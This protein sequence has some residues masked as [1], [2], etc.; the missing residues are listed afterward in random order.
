M[1]PNVEAKHTESAPQPHDLRVCDDPIDRAIRIRDRLLSNVKFLDAD[2]WAKWRGVKSNPSAALGKYKRQLRVF[3]V[4]DSKQDLYPA[5]QFADT[6]EPRAEMSQILRVVPES[7]R[8][9]PL[10]SWFEARNELLDGRKPSDV[11]SK[12]PGAV[13]RAVERFYSRDD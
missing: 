6:A 12:N 8:G 7:A 1:D 5:F 4:R 3:A 2:K 13:V 9:W 11:F 10:L